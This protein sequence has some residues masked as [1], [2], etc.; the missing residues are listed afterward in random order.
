MDTLMETQKDNIIGV[1]GGNNRNHN[2]TRLT[3]TC[4]NIKRPF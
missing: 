2:G 1:C 3:E 4:E